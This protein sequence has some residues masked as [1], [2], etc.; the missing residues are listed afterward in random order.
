MV[1]NQTQWGKDSELK[2]R[3]GNV[4]TAESCG[5]HFEVTSKKSSHSRRTAVE[6]KPA[7]KF[8]WTTTENQE[9]NSRSVIAL[10]LH[11]MFLFVQ[12]MVDSVFILFLS[13]DNYV[14]SVVA[15][16]LLCWWT[17]TGFLSVRHFFPRW[18][19]NRVKLQRKTYRYTHKPVRHVEVQMAMSSSSS[20]SNAYRD[21]TS[22][23]F[24]FKNFVPCKNSLNR[25]QTDGNLKR[26]D[27]EYNEYVAGF[28]NQTD[29][30]NPLF[31]LLYEALH[32]HGESKYQLTLC[33]VLCAVSTEF[34]IRSELSSIVTLQII[35]QT[36]ILAEYTFLVYLPL[37]VYLACVHLEYYF[38]LLK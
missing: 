28:P 17:K 26:L 32:C 13:P 21:N 31:L 27:L 10:F 18:C 34:P 37:W 4:R 24:H 1:G 33:S 3:Y 6:T 15:N 16:K 36:S 20:S 30:W 38:D 9:E 29:W 8:V 23:G 14:R 5:P 2:T 19:Y 25:F 11:E 22:T 7:N 35:P 12:H